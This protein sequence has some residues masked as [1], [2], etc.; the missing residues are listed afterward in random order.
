VTTFLPN[1]EHAW[2]YSV[3]IPD[4]AHIVIVLKADAVAKVMFQ[5]ESYQWVH[6]FTGTVVLDLVHLAYVNSRLCAW[7][8]NLQQAAQPAKIEI[9]HA[10]PRVV[11]IM[12]SLGMDKIMAIT[13]A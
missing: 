7:I 4:P 9:R 1:P 11:E 3:T 6:G 12:R 2:P 5:R 13:T 10:S 8:I